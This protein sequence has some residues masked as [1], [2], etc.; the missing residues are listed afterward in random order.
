MTKIFDTTAILAC[1]QL[2]G[3]L[4]G[5]LTSPAVRWFALRSADGG[6]DE[7]RA[8]FD[9]AT[10]AMYDAFN[11]PVAGFA[12]NSHE[13]YL[14]VAALAAA[15][16]SSL[17]A[18]GLARKFRAPPLAECFMAEGADGTIDTLFAATRSRRA[19]PWRPGARRRWA[20]R[21]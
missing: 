2:A 19:T 17:T 12:T 15:C 3:A 8:W 21:S 10:D 20:R 16:S 11:S 14:D 18:A 5:M 6:S 4:H 1:E 7:A 9:A 13:T